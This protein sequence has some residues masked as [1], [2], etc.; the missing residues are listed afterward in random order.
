MCFFWQMIVC[1]CALLICEASTVCKCVNLFKFELVTSIVT[2]VESILS[3]IIS[4]SCTHAESM[5]EDE[6]D[7]RTSQNIYQLSLTTSRQR[8]YLSTSQNKTTALQSSET[9]CGSYYYQIGPQCVLLCPAGKLFLCIGK[10]L[11]ESE[12]ICKLS[13]GFKTDACSRICS[14]FGVLRT[15][16]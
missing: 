16:V 4:P 1:M 2:Y 5:R 7:A 10:D 3:S 15:D 11:T 9:Q 14:D 12:V 6:Q 13:F 8:K